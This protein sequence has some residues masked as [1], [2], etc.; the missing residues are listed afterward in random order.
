MKEQDFLIVTPVLN[1]ECFIKDCIYSVKEAFKRVTYKHIIVDGGSKDE[2]IYLIK[3]NAHQDL[4]FNV[5]PNS[6]MYQALN[7]GIQCMQAK[8]V[9]QLNADDLILPGTPKLIASL[10]LHNKD[11]D[12]ISGSILSVNDERKNCKLK[13]PLKNHFAINKIGVNLFVNQPSTFIRHKVLQKEN[14]FN[15]HFRY[16]ADTELW[17][18]LIREGYHFLRIPQCLSINRVH[19]NCAALT[20]QHTKEL[21]EVRKMYFANKFSAPITKTSNSVQFIANQI[22]AMINIKQIIDSE[23]IQCYSNILSRVISVLFSITRAGC[24]INVPPFKNDYFK[25]KGRI[26]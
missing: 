10:F 8:Y 14:G 22:K 12:V 18:R 26:Y 20:D 16:A 19:N 6:S 23:Y 13:V 5:F 3:N 7:K 21:R 11:I 2:T 25:F 17:L 15:E 1:G 4:I 9:Y 24:S